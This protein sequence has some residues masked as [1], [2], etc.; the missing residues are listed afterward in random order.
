MLLPFFLFSKLIIGLF[1]STAWKNDFLRSC[2]DSQINFI[3][4]KNL[5]KAFIDYK[6]ITKINDLDLWIY[7]LGLQKISQNILTTHRVSFILLALP[8][9]PKVL[10]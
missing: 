4:S 3:I 2:K 6:N 10:C 8:M 7:E 5:N 1:F 9:N